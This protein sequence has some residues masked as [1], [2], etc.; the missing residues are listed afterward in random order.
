MVIQLR[1]QRSLRQR[2]LQLVEQAVLVESRLCIGFSQQ[3]VKER[4]TALLPLLL[5]RRAAG[6]K[7]SRPYNRTC[8]R[9][10][11]IQVLSWTLQV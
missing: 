11:T 6:W 9:T 8:C 3:L 2:L 4:V 10:L 7:I 5:G 1:L